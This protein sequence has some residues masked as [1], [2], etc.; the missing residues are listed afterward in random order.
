MN[1]VEYMIRDIG[2]HQ[3]SAKSILMFHTLYKSVIF[4]QLTFRIRLTTFILSSTDVSTVEAVPL[5]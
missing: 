4:D 5:E 3:K 2:A 1:F